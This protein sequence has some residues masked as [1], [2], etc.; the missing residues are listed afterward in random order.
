MSDPVVSNQLSQSSVQG[1]LLTRQWDDVAGSNPFRLKQLRL[2]YWVATED[3]PVQVLIDHQ[4]AVFFIAARDEDKAHNVLLRVLGVS[5]HHPSIVPAWEIKPLNLQNFDGQRVVGVYFREQRA[6]YKARESVRRS[7][8]E[9]L[10]SD[11]NPTDRF[12]MERF[13]HMRTMLMP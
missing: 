3:G 2:R 12:L 10:E 13:L 7:G 5:A 1:F 6:L 9:V 11:I 8:I 4:P